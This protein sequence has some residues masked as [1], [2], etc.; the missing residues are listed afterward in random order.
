MESAAGCGGT[1]QIDY[2]EMQ[3]M[4]WLLCSDDKIMSVGKLLSFIVISELGQP[5][6]QD[7]PMGKQGSHLW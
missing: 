1:N 4:I 5:D 2:R 7:L 6:Y 3:P